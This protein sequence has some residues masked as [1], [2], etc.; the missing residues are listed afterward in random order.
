MITLYFQ[1]VNLGRRG[2][3]RGRNNRRVRELVVEVVPG[4]LEEE[5]FPGMMI[6]LATVIESE[7]IEG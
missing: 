3:A 4:D 2:E 5:V 7:V 1:V 6:E